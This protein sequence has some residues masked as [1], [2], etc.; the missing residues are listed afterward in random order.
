MLG[1]ESKAGIKARFGHPNICSTA[2]GTYLGRYRNF[3][4]S[5]GKVMA[6]L[7]LDLSAARSPK[8]NLYDYI[9]TLAET[10]PDMFGASIAFNAGDEIIKKV[11]DNGTKRS[12][13]H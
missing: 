2:L 4:R 1:N 12:V 8:G 3:R 6:D 10:N 7:H 9:L 11:N 5:A 13:P